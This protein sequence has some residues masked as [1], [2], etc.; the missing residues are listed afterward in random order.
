MTE[1][2]SHQATIADQF[3]RQAEQFAAAPALHNQAALDLLVQAAE[4]DPGDTSL[5]V[6]WTGHRGDRVRWA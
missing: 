3:G 1:T 2:S 6:A 4:P 5:D